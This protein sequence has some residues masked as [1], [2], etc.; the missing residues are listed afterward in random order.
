MLVY[1]LFFVPPKLKGFDT[2]FFC[3]FLYKLVRRKSSASAR[4]PGERVVSPCSCLL[5]AGKLVLVI[6]SGSLATDSAT[7]VC[8]GFGY[9]LNLSRAFPALCKSDNMPFI[10]INNTYTLL[11][12]YL[13]YLHS[14]SI[15]QQSCL[16]DTLVALVL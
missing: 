8:F 13:R 5:N 16:G 9:S 15:T 11:V 4:P 12:V 10:A 2:A 6:G 14:L 3:N 1:G 7:S